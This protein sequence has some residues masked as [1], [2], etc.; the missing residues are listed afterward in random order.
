ME[1]ILATFF[2][3]LPFIFSDKTDD[4]KC[5]KLLQE[6]YLLPVTL[7]SPYLTNKHKKELITKYKEYTN[8][9]EKLK[10]CVKQIAKLNKME[11]DVIKPGDIEKSENNAY[12]F[13]KILGE[14]AF[15]EVWEATDKNDKRVAIKVYT[16]IK[17]ANNDYITEL[18]CL[19]KVSKNCKEYAVCYLDDYILN[20]QPRVVLN[21]IDGKSL[22]YMATSYSKNK[23]QEYSEKLIKNLVL[24]LNSFHKIGITHQD[25]KPDNIMYDIEHETFRYIDWGLCCFHSKKC[26]VR[27]N[28]MT[29]PPELYHDDFKQI[30]SQTIEQ[31]KQHDY[32]S[33]GVTLLQFLGNSI[34]DNKA[35]ANYANITASDI[36]FLTE[37]KRVGSEYAS[38][39]IRKLMTIDP[40]QRSKNFKEIVKK[41]K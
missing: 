14:G 13:K 18:K 34:K 8:K 19:K 20:E 38:E 21:F 24:G 27:G 23:R 35:D 4:L 40:E 31:M 17:L 25:I 2:I 11:F 29:T 26:G 36:F 5:L 1:Y 41:L 12:T 32:W 39:T 7:E 22:F 3:S 30:S 33:L 15:G 10:V 28:V 16:N 37:P 6:E 9:T